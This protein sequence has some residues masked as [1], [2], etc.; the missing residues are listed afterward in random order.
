MSEYGCLQHYF[1]VDLFVVD[2]PTQL[3]CISDIYLLTDKYKRQTHTKEDKRRQKTNTKKTRSFC[4]AVSFLHKSFQLFVF[5]CLVC[6]AY[7]IAFLYPTS[8]I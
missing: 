1:S 5:L 6:K 2:R 3:I 8:R 4:K 7:I